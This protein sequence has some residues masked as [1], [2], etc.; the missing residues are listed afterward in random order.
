MEFFCLPFL[1]FIHELEF[2]RVEYAA[3]AINRKTRYRVGKF[4]GVDVVEFPGEVAG[5][6]SSQTMKRLVISSNHGQR[7]SPF[8]PRFADALTVFR[9]SVFRGTGKETPIVFMEKEP[10]V[11]NREYLIDR[12]SKILFDAVQFSD[13]QPQLVMDVSY[14]G[15]ERIHCGRKLR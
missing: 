1:G 7:P 4:S 6:P 10:Q 3:E 13:R 11:S 8:I 12:A 9:V 2:S 15:D 14:D 5:L